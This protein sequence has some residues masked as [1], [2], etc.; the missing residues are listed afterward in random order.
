LHI[1]K[2]EVAAALKLASEEGLEVID[3]EAFVLI[4]DECEYDIDLP[5][6]LYVMPATKQQLPVAN[7]MVRCCAP[8]ETFGRRL[9]MN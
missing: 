6:F 7:V 8:T 2:E 9:L 5:R 3:L 1:T 4:C